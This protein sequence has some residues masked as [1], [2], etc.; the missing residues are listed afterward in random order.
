MEWCTYIS[1]I[2]PN[3]YELSSS[4]TNSIDGEKSWLSE[5]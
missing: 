5:R 1:W 3:C 2:Y 4:F